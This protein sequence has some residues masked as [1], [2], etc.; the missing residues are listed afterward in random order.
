MFRKARQRRAERRL[1]N[2][3]D[4]ACHYWWGD[5]GG[6]DLRAERCPICNPTGEATT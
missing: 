3:R 2:D 5:R 4:Y 6:Y 1:H